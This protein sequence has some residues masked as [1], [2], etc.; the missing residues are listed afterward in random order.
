MH[1]RE[2]EIYGVILSIKNTFGFIQAIYEDEQYYFSEREFYDNMKVA[3]KV[4]FI[5]RSSQKGPSAHNVRYLIPTFTKLQPSVQGSIM[6]CP[7]RH[8]SGCGL[9]EVDVN[10]VAN[11]EVKTL[12]EGKL[13]KQI[14]Y[15]PTDI[16]GSSIPKNHFL[17]RGDLVEFTLSKMHDSNM[18][19]AAELKLKQ[20]K[21]DRA[22]ALEIQRMLEAGAIREVGVVS[23]IK[24]KEYGFIRA[25]DRKEEIY[26]RL[27]DFAE[28]HVNIEEVS[29]F[30][31]WNDATVHGC[32]VG[33]GGE[34][35]RDMRSYQRQGQ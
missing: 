2:L 24:N 31:L 12:L 10:S 20:V 25:Q 9:V 27:D 14:V 5:P 19:V 32:K 17:D 18:I 13:K 30:L 21:R 23:T 8:R 1:S 11:I 34:L 4:A 33:H 3:D 26:F 28:D 16:V 7:E 22:I 6:R 29:S 35:F 15:R